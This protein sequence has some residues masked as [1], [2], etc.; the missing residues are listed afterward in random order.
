[1]PDTFDILARVVAEM[2]GPKHWSF[3][4]HDEDGAK[5][6]VVRIRGTN[7]YE[8]DEPFI[9]DHFH[10]V[11][12]TTFNEKTWRRWV[13]DKCRA[14]MNHELGELIRWGEER[15]FSPLH[16]PGEDPY[17][18]VEYRAPTDALTTQDGSL[19]DGS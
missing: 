12:I 15:P 19:R 4:L 1:M 9:V 5:R 14:T 13:F 7:N 18:V 6:F 8:P 2:R 10:P 16:G 17:V 11:P 3:R